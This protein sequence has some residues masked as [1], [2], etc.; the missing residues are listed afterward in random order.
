MRRLLPT[1]ELLAAMHA[2]YRTIVFLS[3]CLFEEAPQLDVSGRKRL[4]VFI[5]AGLGAD[6]AV[7]ADLEA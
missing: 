7:R 2:W 5:I 1:N 3:L 4:V 6:V